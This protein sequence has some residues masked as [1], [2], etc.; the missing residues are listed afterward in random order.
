MSKLVDLSIGIKAEDPEKVVFQKIET[1]LT[2]FQP[3]PEFTDDIYAKAANVQAL[4][5][6][7]QGGYGIG[8]VLINQE[9]KII[10]LR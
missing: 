2:A 4:K 3:S 5:S 10:M 7:M 1:Y 9:G 6:V 8:S